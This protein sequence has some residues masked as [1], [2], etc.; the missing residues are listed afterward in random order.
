MYDI[1]YVGI[2]D[3]RHN[4]FLPQICLRPSG[5]M[6][7]RPIYLVLTLYPDTPDET[8]KENSMKTTD[9]N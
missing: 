5:A 2:Y 6:A 8:K 3:K 4:T 7:R 1:V 9:G